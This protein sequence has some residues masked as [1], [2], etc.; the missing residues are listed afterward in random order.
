MRNLLLGICF[1]PLLCFSQDA[2]K[3][4]KTLQLQ[5]DSIE[6][7]KAN[8]QGNIDELKLQ[9]IR[10]DLLD[11]GLPELKTGEEIIAHSAYS[12]V[13]SEQHEQAKWVAHIIIPDIING[14]TSRSNDFR[15][16]SLIKTGSAIEIDY[17]L[18]SLNPDKKDEYIYDWFGFD[19]GHLA[20][21]ADFRWSKKAVL[22]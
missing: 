8:I 9:K 17:G 6:N 14:K 19:R 4:I 11:V 1:F 18:K 2:E 10:E 16:D 12:L 5:I 21:S 20:P 22:F 3:K 13:Y 7:Q 15:E